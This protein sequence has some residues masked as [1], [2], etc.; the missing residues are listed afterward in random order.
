[1]SMKK[2]IKVKDIE[3][4]NGKVT[5]Q[6]MLS[7]KTTLVEENLADIIALKNAGCHIVRV[8]VSNDDEV[9]AL[10]KICEKSVLPIVA[11]IQFD[12][13][14]AI[15]SIEAGASKIRINPSNIGD[16][17][18][19]ELICKKAKEYGIPI[20]VGVNMGSLD[21]EVEAKYGRT[22]LGLAKSCIKCAE[23]LESFDFFD[24]VLSVKASS[25]KTMVEAC[26]ILHK[27]TDYPLHI[28]VTEAGTKETGIIKNAVGIGALLL[29][30]IGDTIRISL[31]A[32]PIEEVF[33]S[34]RLLKSL[35]L[36]QG[37]T[38]VSCPTCSRCN[39]DLFTFAKEI[40]EMTFDI[41][42]NLHIAVMGCVV[43]GIGEGKDADIG[44]AGGGD[45]NFVI[46]KQGKV[47]KTVTSDNYKEEFLR[48][49]NEKIME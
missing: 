29:E 1:M 43:N 46:F 39:Y 35:N 34:R 19:V 30:D 27:S 47:L 28:G 42:Q 10:R 37:A 15:A 24:I 31:S 36:L 26:K 5:I 7:K 21:S 12:Y 32:E 4:G 44:I 49:I 45:N 40:E 38:V 33:A 22:A 13:K 3:I 6:T 9:V 11:D 25:V 18:K 17:S 48:L 8:A 20:R 23:L 14:M 2:I 16:N 41:K